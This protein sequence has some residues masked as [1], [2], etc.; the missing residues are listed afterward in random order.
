MLLNFN[1]IFYIIPELFLLSFTLFFLLYG[2]FFKDFVVSPYF[3]NLYVFFGLVILFFTFFL[4]LDQTFVNMQFLNHMYVID[5]FTTYIKLFLIVL[6][7]L[8][9]FLSFHYF[10]FEK[11]RVW[12]FPVLILTSLLGMFFLVSSNDFFLVYLSIEF[13]SFCFYILCAIKKYS[14]LSVE[15]A[16]KYFILGSYA[17]VLLLFGISILYISSGTLNFSDFSL[18]LSF[19]DILSINNILFFLGMILFF[20]GIFFKLGL[21]PF[22]YWVPDVYE[23]SPLLITLFFSVLTK[24]SFVILVINL[25]LSLVHVYSFLV[26]FFYYCSLG[27]IIYGTLMSLYQVRVKR[28]LAYSGISHM[29]FII[30]ADRKSVV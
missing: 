24:L 26:D 11:S 21:F 2:L 25:L 30:L 29:G 23:G 9:F 20:V 5:L 16:L 4:F 22:H 3:N 17:S 14:N 27:S 18:I 10:K 28:L 8:F 15:A 1:S 6:F 19:L 13:Q 12:E 7:F